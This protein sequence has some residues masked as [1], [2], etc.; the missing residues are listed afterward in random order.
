MTGPQDTTDQQAEKTAEKLG[1]WLWLNQRSYVGPAVFRALLSAFESPEGVRS[2]SIDQIEQVLDSAKGI[3][4]SVWSRALKSIEEAD[5]E[6]YQKAIRTAEDQLAACREINAHVLTLD[7][8][9]Y[10]QL[11]FRQENVAPPVLYARGELQTGTNRSMAVVGT[12]AATPAGIEAAKS[13]AADAATSGWTIVSGAAAGTDRAAHEGALEV[14]GDTIAVLG[15]GIDQ[16]YPS[17]NEDLFKR[18]WRSGLVV[19]EYPPGTRPSGTRLRKRNKVTVGAADCVV[20]GECPSSSGTL[21][22]ARSAQEQKKPVFVLPMA[23]RDDEKIAGSLRLVAWGDARELSDLEAREVE[24]LLDEPSSRDPLVSHIKKRW[25]T[26]KGLNTRDKLAARVKDAWDDTFLRWKVNQGNPPDFSEA[27]EDLGE[28]LAL[29]QEQS[30]REL[31]N[32]RDSI[33]LDLD[34]VVVAVDSLLAETVRQVL[35]ERLGDDA[36]DLSEVQSLVGYHP[37]AILR[38]YLSENAEEAIDRFQDLYASRYP[39]QAELVEDMDRVLNGLIQA[40]VKIGIVT[41]QPRSRAREVLDKHEIEDRFH[42]VITWNDVGQTKPSPSGIEKALRDLDVNRDRS[43]YVGD[44]RVDFEAARRADLPAIAACWDR[45][46][47]P[48]ILSGKPDLI[49]FQPDQL[50]DLTDIDGS[51]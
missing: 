46:F 48:G 4:K 21:N 8:P 11:L 20:M 12:R 26:L 2:A 51:A 10:P 18:L 13:F 5:E 44:G 40:G 3:R 28:Q 15:C 38:K 24:K 25:P 22:A 33:L 1:P 17:E 16:A 9:E 34:G 50:R 35:T 43:C 32:T 37:R 30:W 14:D 39:Q 7:N 36:P 49:L 42:T 29:Q 41:T 47:G 45:K 19:S 27:L 6:S 31:R 23:G